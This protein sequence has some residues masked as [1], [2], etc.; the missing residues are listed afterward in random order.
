MRQRQANQRQQQKT[1]KHGPGQ[2]DEAT[3]GKA[4]KQD[5]QTKK[6][7]RAVQSDGNWKLH[8]SLGTDQA[9][10]RTTVALVPPKPKELEM[11]TP[12]FIFRASLAQ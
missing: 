10:L 8:D 2:R 6:K 3:G 5:E 12:I 9:C 11:A 1:R 7:S 4:V